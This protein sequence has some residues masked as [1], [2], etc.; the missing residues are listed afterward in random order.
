MSPSLLQFSVLAVLCSALLL[1]FKVDAAA[2]GAAGEA[3]ADF[4]DSGLVDFITPFGNA[5]VFFTLVP[6]VWAIVL[7]YQF[8]SEATEAAK[9]LDIK[10]HKRLE[11]I[12]EHGLLAS[13]KITLRMHFVSQFAKRGGNTAWFANFRDTEIG[14]RTFEASARPKVQR[15]DTRKGAAG[16]FLLSQ[17]HARAASADKKG[18]LP[19]IAQQSNE[20][21]VSMVTLNPAAAD[22]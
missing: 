22:F 8:M 17:R 19:E 2:D 16:A 14:E 4:H 12:C 7:M 15:A 10:F 3:Y 6:L 20:R 9:R 13:Q 18:A 1:Q 5:I 11:Q 21:S